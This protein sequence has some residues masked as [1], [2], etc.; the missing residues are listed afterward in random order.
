[1]D[2][3][4][5]ELLWIKAR[6]PLSLGACVPLAIGSGRTVVETA[7]VE[8]RRKKLVHMALKHHTQ[9]LDYLRSVSAEGSMRHGLDGSVVEAVTDEHRQ[10]AAEKI[11]Q[12]EIKILEKRCRMK[13]PSKSSG[14]ADKKD[15]RPA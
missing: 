14:A 1:M 13:R 5:A 2:D 10:N 4:R 9:S 3:I 7:V 15:G 6:W 12:I 8:G 11:R